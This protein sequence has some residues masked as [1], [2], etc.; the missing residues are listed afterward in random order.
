M[1]LGINELSS[2]LDVCQNQEPCI[3]LR[4]SQ[5]KSPVVRVSILS[6]LNTLSRV[7]SLQGTDVLANPN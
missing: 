7:I 5:N 6:R 4:Y 1:K 3:A 2:C